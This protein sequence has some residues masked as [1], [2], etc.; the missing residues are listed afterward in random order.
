MSQVE[1]RNLISA[2]RISA[3]LLSSLQVS[4]GELRFPTDPP[5]SEWLKPSST[6]RLRIIHKADEASCRFGP[7]GLPT[8]SAQLI[9]VERKLRPNRSRSFRETINLAPKLSE[10]QI[11]GPLTN[12]FSVSEAFKSRNDENLTSP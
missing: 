3:P 8:N 10:W 4:S 9:K 1:G 11:L 6:K 7:R 2:C 12:F 5:E